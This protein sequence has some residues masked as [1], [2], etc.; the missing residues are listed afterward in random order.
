MPSAEQ[1]AAV[2]AFVRTIQSRVLPDTVDSWP[3]AELAEM[4]QLGADRWNIPTKFGGDGLAGPELFQLYRQL[5]RGSLLLTFILTQRNAACQRIISST[6]VAL[7][8]ELL[9]RLARS[10]LFATVGISHLTT[11][12][13]HLSTPPVQV[14]HDASS[15]SYVL[16]GTVPW[17]SAVTAADVVVT[18]GTLPDGTQLLAAIPTVRTGMEV[19]AP[20]S[21]LGMSA[22][23]TASILLHD[24]RIAADEI[25]HG[26]VERVMSQ[27]AGGG[28]GSLGTTAVALGSAEGYLERFEQEITSRPGLQQYLQPLQQEALNLGHDFSAAI[29]ADQPTPELAPEVLRQRANSLV[30]RVSQ[31]WLASTKGAGYVSGHAAEQAVRESLFFLVWSCPQP[32]LEGNL[33]ELSCSGA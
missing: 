11:S 3:A 31:A 16:N 29:A 7:A 5:S 18:G 25:L 12:R 9:P 23:H 8:E 33:R 2:E 19:Q 1:R 6:N 20:V 14:V 27:G 17:A 32:V 10:E 13:Q 21:L 24:V 30:M 15:E 28:A 4:R 26:P 22:S